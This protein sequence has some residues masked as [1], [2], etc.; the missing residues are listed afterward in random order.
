MTNTSYTYKKLNL[1]NLEPNKQYTF[2]KKDN[3]NFK[4]IFMSILNDTL[5]VTNYETDK[6]KKSKGAWSMPKEWIS[7]V[8]SEEF[9]IKVNNYM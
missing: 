6:I 3:T 1:T 5:I 4:A 7:Y 2:Y 8:E 9:K